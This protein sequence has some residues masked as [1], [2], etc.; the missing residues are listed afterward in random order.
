MVEKVS[1]SIQEE[2]I[3]CVSLWSWIPEGIDS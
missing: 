2:V 3:T 1:P